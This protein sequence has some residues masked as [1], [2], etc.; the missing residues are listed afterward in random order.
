MNAPLVQLGT[1]QDLA[2]RLRQMWGRNLKGTRE[3]RELSR[4][5]L[6]EKVGVS[7]AAV[8][9]WERGETSPRPHLQAL[10][11]QALDTR[12]DL[13]FPVVVPT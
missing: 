9:M 2:V 7:E 11:A 13:L 12:H 1:E 10:I 4:A 6:A 5:D 3:L 8:G